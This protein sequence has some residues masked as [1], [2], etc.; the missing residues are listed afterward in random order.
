MER[1]PFENHERCGSLSRGSARGE[2]SKVRQPPD[3]L[4]SRHSKS[5]YVTKTDR[6]ST[7]RIG[8]SDALDIFGKWRDEKLQVR[9]QAS[10]ESHAFASEGRVTAVSQTEV[11]MQSENKLAEV[12]LRLSDEM[13]FNYMDSREISGD[14]ARNYPSCIVV[15]F[16]SPDVVLPDG[17][18]RDLISFAEISPQRYLDPSRPPQSW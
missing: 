4:H 5:A 11:R 13:T 18:T 16:A 7:V 10:F 17:K 9:C 12:V 2:K 14:E 3:A 6:W 1:A 8:R 15:A